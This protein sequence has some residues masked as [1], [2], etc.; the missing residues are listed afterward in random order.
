M[1]SELYLLDTNI[2]SYIANGK[3]SAARRAVKSVSAHASIAISAIT[4]AELLFGLARR[5]EA[6]R[7]RE[8]IGAVLVGVK[9]LPWD[10]DA[11]RSYATLQLHLSQ[12]GKSLGALDALIA[13]HAIATNAVLVTRDA[14]FQQM[15]HLCPTVNWATDL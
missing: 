9:V 7:L 15:G 14:A 2:V 3:S 6:I 10:S 12:S 13:A 5:P 1:P 4:E 11:A 8:S